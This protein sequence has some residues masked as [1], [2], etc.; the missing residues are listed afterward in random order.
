M[1]YERCMRSYRLFRLTND[2]WEA[3]QL[4]FML[5]RLEEERASLPPAGRWLPL[6]TTT[7]WNDLYG[8]DEGAFCNG[9]SA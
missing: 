9:S 7:P 5:E 6:Y 4:A 1:N 2:T 8:P 3:L